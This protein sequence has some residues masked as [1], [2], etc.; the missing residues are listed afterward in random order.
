MHPI[1]SRNILPTFLPKSNYKVLKYLDLTKIVSLL[2]QESLFFCRLDKLEDSFEEEE[3]RLLYTVNSEGGLIY[4]W[5]KE[6]VN[7]G[8]YLKVNIKEL[9]D[10]IIIS[11]YSPNWYYELVQDIVKKYGLEIKIKKSELTYIE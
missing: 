9:I 1:H 11:P 3:V 2:Q 5:S 6:E 10:E 7:Q 8:K 4:D